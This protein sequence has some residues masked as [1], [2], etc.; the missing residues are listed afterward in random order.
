MLLLFPSSY[1]NKYGLGILIEEVEVKKKRTTIY[2][3][4][5]AQIIVNEILVAALESGQKVTITDIV[6]SAIVSFV[7]YCEYKE[8][9]I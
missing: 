9:E 2:L 4:E 1:R 6:N 7:S 3:S 5:S 8:K